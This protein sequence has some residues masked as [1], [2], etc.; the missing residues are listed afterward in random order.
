MLDQLNRKI[1]DYFGRAEDRPRYRVVWSEDEFEMRHGTFN[2]YTSNGLFIRQVT[3]TRQVPKYR[4][5]IQNTYILEQLTIYENHKHDGSMVESLGYEPVYTF[6]QLG[7][8]GIPSFE[9]CKF[10]IE[11]V[12]TGMKSPGDRKSVV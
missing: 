6:R 4:Q 12:I 7:K 11:V 1:E 3:E 10:L 5:W 2:D 9:A 8:E